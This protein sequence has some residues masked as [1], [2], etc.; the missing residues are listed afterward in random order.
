MAK[1][2]TLKLLSTAPDTSALS[3]TISH[4]N[5]SA[6]DAQLANFAVALNGL[7]QNT[8]VDTNR[9]DVTSLS[10]AIDDD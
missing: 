5:P 7:T 10:D 9:I 6:T 8:Y 2:T 3:T 1:T 4:A